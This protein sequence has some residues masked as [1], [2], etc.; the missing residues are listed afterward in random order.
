MESGRKRRK[1]QEEEEEEEDEKMELFYALIQ[2]T[3]A[4]RDG[5]KYSKELT[6]EEKSK[7]VWNPKFQPEDFNEEDG[8]NYNNK[9]NIIP[10]QLSA[11]SSSTTKQFNEKKQ[12]EED[13]HY[14]V[15]EVKKG[16]DLNLSL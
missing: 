13:K 6:E 9:S 5:M 14:K 2:N 11:A 16:L 3:K 10:L 15:V 4:M 7:G 12:Q 1:L 8:Y